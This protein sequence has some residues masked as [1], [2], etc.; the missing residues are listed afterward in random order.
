[1]K[2][3]KINKAGAGKWADPDTNVAQIEVEAGDVVTVSNALADMML[4]NCGKDITREVAKE[5]AKESEASAEE[6]LVTELTAQATALI[7]SLEMDPA[8]VN[9]G[10]DSEG[11]AALVKDLELEQKRKDAE[12]KHLA[13]E[14]EKKA[15][16]DKAAADKAAAEKKATPATKDKAKAESK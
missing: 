6:Q 2:I 14:A 1:M 10:L 13:E 15:A 8:E 5:A 16:A 7:S 12:A 3:I 4:P 9:L 11:L